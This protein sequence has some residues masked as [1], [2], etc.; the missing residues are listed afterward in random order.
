VQLLPRPDSESTLLRRDRVTAPDHVARPWSKRQEGVLKPVF[1][2]V[3]V[4]RLDRRHVRLDARAAEIAVLV[5]E[6]AS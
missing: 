4:V 5:E 6:E 2:V 3:R 1:Q